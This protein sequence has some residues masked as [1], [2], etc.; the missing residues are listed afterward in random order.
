[1]VF[2]ENQLFATVGDVATYDDTGASPPTISA[3]VANASNGSSTSF[4]TLTLTGMSV[5]NG[6]TYTYGIKALNAT[7]DSPL[8]ATDTGYIGHGTLSYQWQRSTDNITFPDLTGATT[9]PYN[10]TTAVAGTTYYY[11][12]KLTATGATNGFSSVD[13]G[14]KAITNTV[15]S[16]TTTAVT[17]IT[18]SGGI[19]GGN[20]TDIGTSNVTERG[21][22]Y[23]TSAYPTTAGTKVA[24][25]SGPYA[26]GAFIVNLTGLAGDTPYH[27][28]AYAINSV[29]TSYGADVTFRTAVP[30]PTPV[31]PN[32]NTPLVPFPNN[33]T[34]TNLIG[35]LMPLELS[36][37][38][39][40][41][42]VIAFIVQL[43]SGFSVRV[44][45]VSLG[46]MLMGLVVFLIMNAFIGTVFG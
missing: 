33:S 12:C 1:M 25:I 40:L 9:N 45:G 4:V 14:F 21:V 8:S 27:I 36:G 39:L 15:P 11:Q 13:T 22:C 26:T 18:I 32:S 46:V 6:A 17:S 34:A 43:R 31:A 38:A 7:G 3:G 37:L 44:I 19:T 30:N 41:V 35:G 16:I 29:G 20:I 28:R 5:S 23:G 42:G 24:Q 10:D 2:G